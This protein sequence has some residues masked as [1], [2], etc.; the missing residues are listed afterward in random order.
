MRGAF[1]SRDHCLDLQ[2]SSFGV[3]L[4]RKCLILISSF[5]QRKFPRYC[6][7]VCVYR[8]GKISVEYCEHLEQ[9]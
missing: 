3:K 4:L 6:R 1:C 5:G 2:K 8:V 9:I 7:K